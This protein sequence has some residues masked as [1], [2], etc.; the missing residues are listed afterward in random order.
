M[1]LLLQVSTGLVSGKLLKKAQDAGVALSIFW[2]EDLREHLPDQL[3][4]PV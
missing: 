1:F 4:V 2:F 3:R